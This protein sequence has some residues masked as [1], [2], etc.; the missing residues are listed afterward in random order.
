MSSKAPRGR[1][2]H[3]SASNAPSTA[4]GPATPRH[5]PPHGPDDRQRASSGNEDDK[6]G[7]PA[8]PSRHAAPRHAQVAATGKALRKIC[9]P[10]RRRGR[11]GFCCASVTPSA[12]R[13]WSRPRHSPSE[14]G[15]C[16]LRACLSPTGL[17]HV[18]DLTLFG[19]NGS[20]RFQAIVIARSHWSS[21]YF[22]LTLFTL[23][24]TLLSFLYITRLFFCFFLRVC[25]AHAP[26]RACLQVQAEIKPTISEY[27]NK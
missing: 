9:F 3:P 18:F 17:R 14:A 15:K 12:A 5:A 7:P 21:I 2:V 20:F 19:T 26:T 27:N 13:L 10:V 1:H 22:T 16:L 8:P 23:A 4:T 24:T 6:E 25:L 11:R